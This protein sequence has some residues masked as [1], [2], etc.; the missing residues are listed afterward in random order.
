MAKNKAGRGG[1]RPKYT[2]EYLLSCLKD[3][4]QKNKRVPEAREFN[5][6][7]GY[8]SFSTYRRRFGCWSNALKRIDEKII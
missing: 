6:V 1:C 4:Y 7:S 3:F 2:D 5:S 8:P